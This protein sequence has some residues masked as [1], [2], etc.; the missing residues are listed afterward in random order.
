[1]LK[2]LHIE[3]VAVIENL[4][5]NF[6]SGMLA[7]TG[8]TG[9]GKS[10]LIDAINVVLGERASKELIRT[11]E[12][13]AYVSAL[14]RGLNQ[15]ACNVLEG[16]GI[17]AEI[18]GELQISREM[19]LDGKSVARI[20][21]RPVTAGM[22]KDVGRQLVSIHGQHDSQ[23][24]LLPERHVEFVDAYSSTE[25]ELSL[26][27]NYYEK[28][29][30]L[31]R[32]IAGLQG[33]EQEKNR[34]AELLRYQIDEIDSACLYVGED[35]EL[36]ERREIIKNAEKIASGV[37]GAYTALYDGENGSAASLVAMA[38]DSLAGIAKYSEKTE[39]AY[40]ALNE[41]S[42]AIDD[43][44]ESVREL[45]N[46]LTFTEDDL[47]AVEDRLDIIYRLKKKYGSSA[48][49]I[50]EYCEKCRAELNSIVHSE[51]RL[52]ELEE[53]Y[54]QNLAKLKAAAEALSKKRKEGAQSLE[55]RLV[56]ELSSMDMKG[57]LF[58]VCA[59]K[60]DYMPN[61][62]EQ[63]EF[64]FS[65]NKGEEPKPLSKI[66]SG[67]ELSRVMLAIKSVLSKAD[68]VDTL[69]FDEI[70]TGVS[71]SAAQK[72]GLKMKAIAASRQ[73][74]CVTHLSQI[75]ALAD[76][77]YRISKSSDSKKTYTKLET[78]DYDGRVN[79]LARIISGVDITAAAIEN[80]KEM[81]K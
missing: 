75:A 76:C 67:G 65:A 2:E 22:L 73:V 45:K 52:L 43:I 27:K 30:E 14:F 31:R 46:S 19:S 79:E 13:T 81:L 55:N 64:L 59:E 63:I 8:E 12:S 58:E 4:T 62:D 60:C 47:S 28:H 39:S 56:E 57:V 24:L 71:G 10:I 72:I 44:V 74:L 32:E 35:K 42:Y 77:H 3:N 36:A 41:I 1:M 7:I 16:L 26:Y 70:D 18:G 49:E 37:M 33:K 53:A 48:E 9:A 69:I 66:A 15:A 6:G 68:T 29:L 78:L 54:N 80:A 38:A 50:L 25:E 17:A 40:N 20:N 51:E 21:G 61:G 11:G 5:V 34:K 23:I